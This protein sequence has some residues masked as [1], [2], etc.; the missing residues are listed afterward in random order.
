PG[1]SFLYS[2]KRA[3]SGS[4]PLIE[5]QPSVLICSPS[6]L[7]II[8][9]LPIAFGL[10][11]AGQGLPRYTVSASASLV[12]V[13]FLINITYSSDNIVLAAVTYPLL[14]SDPLSRE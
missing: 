9:T 13:L 14:E 6:S 5:V 8:T 3:S 4:R 10:P 12:K 1:P 7:S 11:P 2:Y